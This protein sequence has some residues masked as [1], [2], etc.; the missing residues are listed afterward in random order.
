MK[1]TKEELLKS[2]KLLVCKLGSIYGELGKYY[3]RL[4]HPVK[5]CFLDIVPEEH[6]EENFTTE[7]HFS[8]I[9]PKLKKEQDKLYKILRDEYE[10]ANKKKLQGIKKAK[11]QRS[12]HNKKKLKKLGVPS[13]STGL[14]AL[15]EYLTVTNVDTDETT[16]IVDAQRTEFETSLR[17][18]IRTNFESGEE[19]IDIIVDNDN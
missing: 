6:L 7:E 19:E 11:S 18:Y 8:I 12:K 14:E 4:N 15:R 3:R 9:Y 16:R 5:P 17:D 10:E 1:P 13:S 2:N